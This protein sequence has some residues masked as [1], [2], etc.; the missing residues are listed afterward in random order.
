MK[1]AIQIL[2]VAFFAESV[3]Q[4]Q[5]FGP[6][7]LGIYYAAM[8]L[9]IALPVVKAAGNSYSAIFFVMAACYLV[10]EA[11]DWRSI[12]LVM[13]ANGFAGLIIFIIC[14]T[15]DLTNRY[16]GAVLLAKFILGFSQWFIY[17][18]PMEIFARLHNLLSIAAWIWLANLANNSREY[19]NETPEGKLFRLKLKA[20]ELWLEPSPS[21]KK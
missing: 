2:I 11:S 4:I 13:M 7:S 16:I 15:E 12:E 5:P 8:V 9:A 14:K 1:I 18:I 6:E 3:A 21:R 20:F 17:E 10:D 19:V